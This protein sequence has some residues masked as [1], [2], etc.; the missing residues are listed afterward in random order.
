MNILDTLHAKQSWRSD[1]HNMELIA[2]HAGSGVPFC[3]DCGDWH[4]AEDEHSYCDD[5]QD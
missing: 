2:F 5:D 1:E 3:A 4:R